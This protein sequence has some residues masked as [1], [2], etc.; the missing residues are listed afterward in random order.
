MS[1]TRRQRRIRDAVELRGYQAKEITWEPWGPAAEKSGITG[2]WTVIVDRPYLE[3]SYP[4]DDLFG[5]SVD[6]VLADIDYWLKPPE[7][8]HCDLDHSALRASSLINDP[9][10]PTHSGNCPWYIRYRLPWWKRAEG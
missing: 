3:R 8:C 2:G 4:G 1:E 5:L 6:E 7:P 9:E 10:K